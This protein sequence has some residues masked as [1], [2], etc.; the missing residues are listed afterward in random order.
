VSAELET[1]LKETF[2]RQQQVAERLDQEQIERGMIL[3][4][5]QVRMNMAETLFQEMPD[6][7]KS[8]LRKQKGDAL[9]QQDRFQRLA[10]QA[11]EREIDAAV[12]QDIARKEAPP[13]EKWRL[14]KQAQQA[15]LAFH[16]PDGTMEVPA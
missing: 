10:P 3:E 14:R 5:E 13:Y 15:V 9:R 12:M 2:R 8:L 7:K 6:L 11:Q 1:A 16:E 4:Y